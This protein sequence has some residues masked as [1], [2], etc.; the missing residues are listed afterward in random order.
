MIAGELARPN[1]TTLARGRRTNCLIIGLLWP[2]LANG[3]SF[4]S[5]PSIQPA[6][7][8]GG[9]VWGADQQELCVEMCAVMFFLFTCSFVVV[10]LYMYVC[11]V[12]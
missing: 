7:A 9:Q 10:V 11:L 2:F 6:L 4:C 12:L 1:R 3:G 8:V 5:A